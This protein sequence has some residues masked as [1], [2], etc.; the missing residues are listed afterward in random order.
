MQWITQ[1]VS[2]RME[3]WCSGKMITTKSCSF[4][5]TITTN[6]IDFSE[7]KIRPNKQFPKKWSSTLCKGL[8]LNLSFKTI[9]FQT[10]F[11]EITNY[12]GSIRVLHITQRLPIGNGDIFVTHRLLRLETKNNTYYCNTCS[13]AL[14]EPVHTSF[15]VIPSSNYHAVFSRF[16]CL[17]SKRGPLV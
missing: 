8:D 14:Y 17:C 3:C 15:S 5:P 12:F 9:C 2:C 13:G 16:P 10:I 7:S 1:K 6:F 11:D 4:L